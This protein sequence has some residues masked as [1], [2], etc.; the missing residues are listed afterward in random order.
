MF[1]RWKLSGSMPSLVVF[2]VWLCAY[3]NCVGWALSALHQLNAGGYAVTLALG[4]VA[5]IIWRRRTS[6]RMFPALRWQKCFRRFRQP[7]P[8]AFLALAMLAALGGAL[9]SASNYDAMAY[10]IPRVLHWLAAGQ[11]H[12]I[13]S[14]FPRLNTRTAGFEWLSAPQFLFLKTDRFVF[15]FN[16]VSFLLLP[17]RVFAILRRLGVGPRASWYWMWLFPSGYGYVLQAGSVAND[18]FGAFM[19]FVAIEFALRAR[20]ERRVSR[21]WT[22]GLAA[23]LMTAAKAFN[24]V[25]LLPWAVAMFPALKLVLRR[26]VFSMLVAVLAIGAS[27]LPTAYLNWRQCGDWTGLKVEQPTVGG[28]GKLERFA[29]N[30]VNAILLNIEPPVFPF[31]RQWDKFVSRVVPE[32]ASEALHNR[33]EPGLAEFK[34]PELQVEEAAGLGCGV[35]LML[36]I[37]LAKKIRVKLPWPPNP[38][39]LS[40][41]LLFATCLALAVLMMESGDEG[42][43]RYLL[44]FYLL[45]AAPCLTGPTAG[46]IF[47]SRAWRI[48]G[49]MVFATAGMLLVINPARPLGPINSLLKAD[50]A[51]HSSHRLWQRIRTVYS[52]YG[53]RGNCFAP[54]LAALPPEANPL[55][56]V[57]WDEPEA[58]LW[59]PFGARRIEH[60]CHSDTPEE[61]RKRD[62]KYALVCSRTLTFQDHTTLTNWLALYDADPVKIFMLQ[63][64]AGQD[65][66]AWALVKFKPLPAQYKPV[67]APN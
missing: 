37:L 51:E 43:G 52:V 65:P 11:W 67:A 39:N 57:G 59:R 44:P 31:S 36:I 33:M 28:K 14:D 58:A 46:A 38:L 9:H 4:V 64:R 29:A 20:Q 15:L 3:L 6:S 47:R 66:Y 32:R 42:I 10:R 24:L 2:W 22:S 40:V 53:L 25:L 49:Y 30:A 19:A 1:V 12:W 18:M 26:P 55:G 34:L 48:V 63:L 54:V 62:L 16:T 50:D 41:A 61:V 21:L 60:I 23:A 35:T 13:H 8:L 17:G 5:L 56:F 27:L 7:F 45:L